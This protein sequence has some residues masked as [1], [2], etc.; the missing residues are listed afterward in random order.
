[1]AYMTLCCPPVARAGSLYL[2]ELDLV[3]LAVDEA[4]GADRERAARLRGDARARFWI[5]GSVFFLQTVRNAILFVVA[6]ATLE[7]RE[8][9]SP[10]DF[11]GFA[12]FW[13]L[14]ILFYLVPVPTQ[15]AGHGIN[16]VELEQKS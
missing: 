15:P 16:Y 10:R 2:L 11:P 12:A 14:Q 9:I 5:H 4:E 7:S 6:V 8:A 13:P 1:M 3:L